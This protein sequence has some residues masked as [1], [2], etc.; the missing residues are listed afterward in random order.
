MDLLRVRAFV[1]VVREG[2]FSK[3]AARLDRSQ[4]TLTVAVGKLEA[5]LGVQLFERAGRGVRLTRAG[6]L[7]LQE[8]APLVDSWE[9]AEGRFRS[10]L[11][12]TAGGLLRLAGDETAV[13]HVLPGPLRK[14][15]RTHP[16]VEVAVRSLP[17]GEVLE[18]LRS[19]ASDVAALPGRIPVAAGFASRRLVAAER[20]LIAVR[21]HPLA[22]GP[23]PSLRDIAKYPLVLPAAGT[24]TRTIL[25]AAFSEA[26][27][28]PRIALDGASWEGMKRYVG[29]GLGVGVLPS[30]CMAPPDR[31]LSV[32]SAG[33]LF[34]RE[35]Y[36]LIWS[37]RTKPNSAVADLLQG[38]SLSRG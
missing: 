31:R 25:D 23:R 33:H 22:Q 37:S 32:R 2:G 6:H 13:V 27:L 28:T 1:A 9:A 17:R 5:S 16:R 34:G 30:F 11:T 8:V 19:G 21:E 14:F 18:S 12:G 7:F 36:V 26:G 3:A 38:F 10:V 35:S 4:P 29:L 24:N 15:L 20:V